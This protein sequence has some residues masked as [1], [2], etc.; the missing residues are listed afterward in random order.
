MYNFQ[1]NT[2]V[3]FFGIKILRTTGIFTYKQQID[4]YNSGNKGKK[5]KKTQETPQC[6]GTRLS[7]VTNGHNS[8]K[9]D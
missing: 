1:I 4:L 8:A 2:L 9:T 5:R 6:D 7:N 3:F